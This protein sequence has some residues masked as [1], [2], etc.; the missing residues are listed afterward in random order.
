MTDEVPF[1]QVPE[2]PKFEV[3]ADILRLSLKE[4]K[5]NWKS[6]EGIAGFYLGFLVKKA[7]D[8]AK[9]RNWSDFSSLFALKI[10]RA[11][12]RERV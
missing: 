8:W 2:K 10:G 4:V 7:E 12:C 5:D 9:K 3:V 1:V 6:S 11:S